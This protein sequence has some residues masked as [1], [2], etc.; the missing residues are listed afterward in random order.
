MIV[1]TN[2]NIFRIVSGYYLFFKSLDY[3]KP[4]AEMDYSVFLSTMVL[5]AT[6]NWGTANPQPMLFNTKVA[7]LSDKIGPLQK[8]HSLKDISQELERKSRNIS[9]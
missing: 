8:H 7:K 5:F 9:M 2:I 1:N 4:F 6:V 3:R